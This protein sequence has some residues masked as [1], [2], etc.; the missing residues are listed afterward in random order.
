MKETELVKQLMAGDREAF[1]ALY[2]CYKDQAFRTAWFLAGNR[3]DAEDIVQ[4][5]FVRHWHT[6]SNVIIRKAESTRLLE[7]A[8][9]WPW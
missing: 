8:S 2:E 5:T 6:Y 9:V 1:D 4:D 7:Q 3:A